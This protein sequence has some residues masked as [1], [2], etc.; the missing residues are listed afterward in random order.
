MQEILP[1]LLNGGDPTPVLTIPNWLRVPWLEEVSIAEVVDRLT[2]PRA[3]TSHM[4]YHLMPSSFFSSKAKVK[5]VKWLFR[6]FYEH[7]VCLLECSRKYWYWTLHCIF[8][9]YISISSCALG[10]KVTNKQLLYV[11]NN[12]IIFL[13]SYCVFWYF[14]SFISLETQRML[15]FPIII[16]TKWAIFCSTQEPLK[17]LLTTS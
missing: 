14:R 1:S 15:W 13:M 5:C 10:P 8:A 4:P 9:L 6:S 12:H 11:E 7:Y 16:S 2:A 17:N 3:F